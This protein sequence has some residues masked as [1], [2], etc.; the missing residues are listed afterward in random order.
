MKKNYFS[1]TAGILFTAIVSASAIPPG[2]ETPVVKTTT[3]AYAMSLS[4]N[5]G[6]FSFDIQKPDQPAMYLPLEGNEISSGGT[7]ANGK[8]YT[9]ILTADQK[10]LGLYTYNLK[11]GERT[12]LKDMKDAVSF[13]L[14]LTYDYTT[15]TLYALWENW[16]NTTFIKV[17][18]ETGEPTL[19]K[20]ISN[21][22]IYAIAASPEGVLYAMA[23]DGTLY[24]L[25]KDGENLTEVMSTNNYPSGFQ[26]MD[27]D[28][29]SGKLYWVWQTY[30]DRNFYEIDLDKKEAKQIGTFPSDYQ[31]GGLFMAFTN[32]VPESPN[33]LKDLK[34]EVNESLIPVLS[35]TNPDKT[36][37]NKDL[38]NLSYAEIYRN[39]TL[40]NKMTGISKATASEWTDSSAPNQINKYKVITYTSE[41]DESMPAYCSIFAGKDVPAA[42]ANIVATKLSTTSASI[43]WEAPTAGLH[44]S[45]FDKESLTYKI[46]RKPDNTTVAENLKETTYTDENVTSFANYRYQ[47]IAVTV[48]GEGGSTLSNAIPLGESIKMPFSSPLDTKENFE[49]WTVFNRDEKEDSWQFS[50]MNG[51]PR[52][53]AES[54][55][56]NITYTPTNNWLISPPL[57]LEKD[58]IYELSFKANTSYYEKELL[59]ITLGKELTPEAQTTT[60]KDM[61]INSYYGEVFY[62]T[63][64]VLEE[65][66]IYYLGLQHT[67][68]GAPGM[69]LHINDVLL[70]EQD[71]GAVTGTVTDGTNPVANVNLILS[72]Q[73]TITT[74]SDAEGKYNFTDIIA[75]TYTLKATLLG[76]GEYET[77]VT[78]TPLDTLKNDITITALPQYSVNGKITD[79]KDNPIVGALVSISG[80]DNHQASTNEAGEYT[81]DKVYKHTNYQLTVRKNNFEVIT[82]R[83]LQVEDNTTYETI[84]LTYKNLPPYSISATED[85]SQNGNVTLEW[86]RPI[87]IAEYLYDNNEPL[88]PLGYDNGSEYHILG[89]IYRTPTTIHR[90]KWFTNSSESKKPYVHVY[91]F[92]LDEEGNPTGTFLFSQKN[93]PTQ[94]DQWTTFEL[95]ER[96]K[97]PRGFMLA[98]SGDGNIH[99]A[100]DNNTEIIGK[101]IQC[102]STNYAFPSSYT[103]FDDTNWEGALMLRAEGEAI[104]TSEY[105][106]KVTYDVWRMTEK[107][108]SAPEKWTKIKSGTTDMNAVDEAF[109]SLPMD[110]YKY[111]VKANYSVDNFISEAAISKSIYHKQFT[112]IHINVT[113]NSVP[114]DAEGASISLDDN[115]GNQYQTSVS[116]GKAAFSKIWKGNY[117]LTLTQPGF[118][119]QEVKLDLTG[120]DNYEF[121]YTLIQKILPVSNID[122]MPTEKT[123]EWEL[124]WNLFANIE[125][126]FEGDAYEDFELN[127]VGDTGWQ[128]VDN[129][130][131][132]TYGFGATVFP[133]MREPMAAIIF[134][135]NTTEPPLG[136]N[137]AHTGERALA[138]FAARE[139]EDENE[140]IIFHDSDDY[141]ISPELNFHKDFTFSFFARSYDNENGLERI[142]VGY[143]TTDAKLGSFTYLDKEFIDVPT[144]YKEYSYLIPKEAKY[145]VLNS[146]ARN[147]FLLL[148]D[149]IF[150]GTDKNFITNK[151]E[152]KGFFKNYKVYLDNEVVTE[153]QESKYLLKNL[154]FGKHTASVVKVYNSGESTPVSIDF[155]VSGADNIDNLNSESLIVYL[156]RDN[157]LIIKGDYNA[158]TLYS[159]TGTLVMKVYDQAETDLNRL[160]KGVYM[161]DILTKDN[162]HSVHKII[163]K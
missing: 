162:R 118:E 84:K 159:I 96:I 63:L 38:T 101:H 12:L 77:E 5:P 43:S 54:W 99:L 146:H 60:L 26:S 143:S 138:F 27:F 32:A 163:L 111:A 157:K 129:D 64:P 62:I 19:I 154:S 51:V 69:V 132:P 15:S 67:S 88:G 94:D 109:A 147:S 9:M 103:Y 2:N 18:T 97:A 21:K 156:T 36:L 85:A 108:Q 140:Q 106:V 105:P 6:I 141:L 3:K 72:G 10:P 17:N 31:V 59:K 98:L 57:Y 47:I 135:S 30:W 137:T 29:N 16:P 74:Q 24:T 39:D 53:G 121:S 115:K 14:D 76:Y 148:V 50:K 125:D 117:V 58:K 155:T 61:E 93:I 11:S 52:D 82:D 91:I 120:E 131:Y 13:F 34:V 8:Y 70:K 41:N 79:N 130:R 161:V 122:I 4:N 90:V 66:G 28:H 136:I 7:Y 83:P 42:P 133:H 81:F 46:V 116:N 75:G 123:T 20:E 142:R 124:L 68:T 23:T 160:E 100:K 107:D 128:C 22:S 145:V 102:F 110:T 151:E 40:V 152:G 89:N 33:T 149:D 71:K 114:E 1:L 37:D 55:T 153:T 48:D 65:S 104:E 78:V 92:D 35:W 80:Y 158:M 86:E 56:D 87:D 144:E 112:D 119:S 127:P 44:N 139:T 25:S 45:W 134:N 113:T 150:I 95:P 126:G 49:L 73:D